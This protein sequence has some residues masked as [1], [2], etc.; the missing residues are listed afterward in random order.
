[1][2]TLVKVFSDF[3]GKTRVIDEEPKNDFI[4][5]TDQSSHENLVKTHHQPNTNSKY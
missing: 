5:N 4:Y 2:A 3:I 1:M